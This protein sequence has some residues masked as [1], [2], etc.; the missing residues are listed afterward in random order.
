MVADVSGSCLKSI[1]SFMYSGNL[2]LTSDTANLMLLVAM[3][4]EM[5]DLIELCQNYILNPHD[6]DPLAA[7]EN[8]Q[9]AGMEMSTVKLEDE[10]SVDDIITRLPLCPSAAS[11]TRSKRSSSRKL[12]S[13]EANRSSQV[14]KSPVASKNKQPGRRKRR[15]SP[16][17]NGQSLESVLATS[18]YSSKEDD[19]DWK[20]TMNSSSVHQY[21]A[22][23]QHSHP[24][25]DEP[26]SSPSNVSV[27]N[28][29]RKHLFLSS[30]RSLLARNRL[31]LITSNKSMTFATVFHSPSWQQSRM[32]L[33]AARVFLAKRME[34]SDD[35]LLHCRQ[36]KTEGVRLLSRLN[37]HILRQHKQ[38]R[39]CF[40]CH[41]RF[42]SFAALM[43]HRNSKHRCVPYTRSSV[44]PISN[45]SSVRAESLHNK[46]GWCGL[47]FAARSELL[48]HREM[49]HRRRTPRP[50]PTVLCRRVTRHWNC[51]EK[52]C[53]MQFKHKD[54]LRSHMAECHPN[55][56]FS[57][58]KCRFKTQ[59]EHFL[60]R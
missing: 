19:P 31:H 44:D 7:K 57:C 27:K 28:D 58:P 34:S 43:R 11:T 37:A 47:K 52:D 59:I 5:S 14:N 49:V 55:V 32:I 6:S 9:I 1:V 50:V 36:C 16:D 17:T 46:C 18:A 4:L 48:E 54:K 29:R 13:T 56:I 41:Q 8:A 33:L 24:T 40:S 53:R 21:N 38:W 26:L 22:Q 23:K 15:R 35:G 42:S 30:R 3:Q 12:R 10:N 45:S 51:T 2:R 25:T 60:R 20:P 39:S